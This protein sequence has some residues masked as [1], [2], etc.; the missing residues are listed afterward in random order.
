[1]L[2]KMLS[3]LNGASG[4]EKKVR[5]FIKSVVAPYVDEIQVD[6]MGNLYAYKGMTLKGPKVLLAAHMDEV[7]LMITAIT[8]DG[9]LKFEP[10]GGIDPRIL[11]S[12]PVRIGESVNGIIGTKAIHLQKKTERENALQFKD[13]Y[14]DIGATSREE[15]SKH[16]KLGDYAHFVNEYQ[17][18]GECATGKALDDRVGCAVLI[19]LLKNDYAFPLIAAFTVQEEV[20]LRGAKV[21]AY[22]TSPDFALVIECTLATD[23][24]GTDEEQWITEIGKGPAISIMDRTTLFAPRL[25]RFATEVARA[26]GIPYQFRRGGSGGNDAGQI[27]LTRE[28]IPT[29][30]LSVPCRYIHSMTSVI[31]EQDYLNTIRLANEILVELPTHFPQL[32]PSIPQE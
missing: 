13:L 29:L 30:A 25:I 24:L 4:H 14:I 18:L 28:G 22:R 16:V 17:T 32:R 5:D 7:G 26:K 11:V 12:K 1:M 15:A 3:E 6:T 20:G 27:H 31:S 9:F 8:D 21:A 2:L 10:V 19:E 23:T